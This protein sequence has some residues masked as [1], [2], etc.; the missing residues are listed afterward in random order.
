M[1]V[2]TSAYR[3]GSLPDTRKLVELLQKSLLGQK[4]RVVLFESVLVG[5]V[6]EVATDGVTLKCIVP[7]LSPFWTVA[8]LP[9]AYRLFVVMKEDADLDA[10]TS[11]QLVSH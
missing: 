8:S 7:G 3:S 6:Q 11:G 9:V 1:S 2:V 10:A 4:V 5:V